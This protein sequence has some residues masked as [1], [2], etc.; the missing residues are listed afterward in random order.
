MD[1]VLL[2]CL[3]AIVLLGMTVPAPEPPKEKKVKKEA[4]REEPLPAP[5][6]GGV[7]LFFLVIV[8]LMGVL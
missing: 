7:L 4:K 5:G 3:G 1:V 6:I 8:L 2:F